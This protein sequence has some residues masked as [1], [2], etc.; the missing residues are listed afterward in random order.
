M[1]IIPPSLLMRVFLWSYL[2]CTMR[3]GLED[4]GATKLSFLHVVSG[5]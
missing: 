2:I 5:T 4:L 1:V 3:K